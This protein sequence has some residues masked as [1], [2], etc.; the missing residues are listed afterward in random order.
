MKTRTRDANAHRVGAGGR[1]GNRAAEIHTQS[2]PRT[3]TTAGKKPC[4]EC[5][6][7]VPAVRVGRPRRFCSER[8]AREWR[9]EDKALAREV[10]SVR[11]E[12]DNELERAGLP[13]P[14]F[15]QD[16]Y[17][18]E[19]ERQETRRR[20]RIAGLEDAL[21]KAIERRILHGWEGADG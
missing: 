14:R 6:G 2:P 13:M 15:G 19:Y 12:L 5:G 7:P 16:W 1:D 18:A 11:L 21:D 9:N 8:C 4:P 20:L 17:R 3:P 10:V